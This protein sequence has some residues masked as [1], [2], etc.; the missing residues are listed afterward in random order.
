MTSWS[1]Y[2]TVIL[3]S[4]LYVLTICRFKLRKTTVFGQLAGPE[5]VASLVSYLASPEAHF[6][7]GLLPLIRRF[8][9]L[10]LTESAVP[11]DKQ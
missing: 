5:E 11:Q 10:S 9:Y 7:T 4:G 8:S 2:Y 1:R 6:I 3:T